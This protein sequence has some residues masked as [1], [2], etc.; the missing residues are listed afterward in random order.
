MKKIKSIIQGLYGI[1]ESKKMIPKESAR[2]TL[3]KTV[4]CLE[5]ALEQH[6]Q[7]VETLIQKQ[8]KIKE[9]LKYRE[10]AFDGNEFGATYS[11]LDNIIEQISE[12]I[13]S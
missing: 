6:N 8:D 1:S 11:D 7:E 10:N 5:I 13:N 2:Y 3:N 12:I 4:E 9:I